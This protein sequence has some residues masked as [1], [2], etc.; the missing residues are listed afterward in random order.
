M[1]HF[2]EPGDAVTAALELVQRVP[3]AGLGLISTGY[4]RKDSLT[5]S[6]DRSRLAVIMTL[7][8]PR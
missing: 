3:A 6:L 5:G 4:R 2:P 7:S 8:R 1:F